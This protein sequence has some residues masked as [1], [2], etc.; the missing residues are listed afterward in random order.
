M[1]HSVQEEQF[2]HGSWLDLVSN[3]TLI[4]SY[5]VLLAVAVHLHLHMYRKDDFDTEVVIW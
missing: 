5:A 1:D 4:S 3:I 2:R